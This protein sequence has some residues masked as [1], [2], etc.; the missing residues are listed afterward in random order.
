MGCKNNTNKKISYE[1]IRG[2][3]FFV[4]ININQDLE[5][6]PFEFGN[7]KINDMEYKLLLYYTILF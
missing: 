1:K 5:L 6:Y 7:K 2:I 4:N 3:L